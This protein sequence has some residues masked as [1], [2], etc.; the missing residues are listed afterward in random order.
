MMR[1]AESQP[2]PVRTAWHVLNRIR[3]AWE[4]HTGADP[5][6]PQEPEQEGKRGRGRPATMRHPAPIPDSPDNI[7]RAL[8]AGPPKKKWRYLESDD[9]ETG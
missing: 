2:L 7:A 9:D 5:E 6:P 1:K 3:E 4:D 8:M